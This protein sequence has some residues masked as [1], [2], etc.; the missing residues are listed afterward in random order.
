VAYSPPSPVTPEIVVRPK[1][2]KHVFSPVGVRIQN[3]EFPQQSG[4]WPGVLLVLARACLLAVR[5]VAEAAAMLAT[6]GDV[7]APGAEALESEMVAFN[8]GE[9]RMR[10]LLHVGF[11]TFFRK[12][13]RRNLVAP[14]Q[15]EWPERR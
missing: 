12:T 11:G 14:E 1:V 9:R 10:R 3:P 15:I 2:E 7:V 5:D 4:E 6:H 13:S 8:A